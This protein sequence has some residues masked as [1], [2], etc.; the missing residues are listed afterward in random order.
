MESVIRCDN[1][2]VKLDGKI[3]LKD[4]TFDLHLGE[5]VSVTGPSACG[6]TLF[7]RLMAG[8]LQK[9]AGLFDVHTEVKSVFVEQQDNFFAQSGIRHTYY[10]QRYEYFE[11]REVPTVASL[12]KL[13]KEAWQDNSTLASLI[14]TLNIEYLLDRQLLLLSNGERKR[15]QIVAALL[16]QPT[17]LVFDQPFIGLDIES[18]RIVK[19]LLSELKQEGKTV[20]LICSKRDVPSF[21]DRWV[22]MRKGAIETILMP[23]DF[24]HINEAHH[25]HEAHFEAFDLPLPEQSLKF[26]TII[27]MRN[28]NVAI[29]GKTILK[30]I[31]WEVK[32]G[33]RW[34][35]SGHNGSGKSTLLSLVTADNPHG[36]N[37][38]LV[39]FD[40]KRGTGETVWE[41]KKKIGFVSPELHL[42]F[43]RQTH[44]TDH[45]GTLVHS[46][47]ALSVVVSG[48]ND[49]IG[50]SSKPT[51]YQEKIATQ[52]LDSLGLGH[53]KLSQ[54]SE[55]SLGE[56]RMLLLIRA[57]IKNP[58]LLIL[59]EPCQGI[60]YE[61][62]RRFIK[63]LDGLC[64]KLETTL[65]YVSHSLDEIPTC[66]THK[67]VLSEGQVVESIKQKI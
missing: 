31:H 10:S 55:L 3:L 58:P 22:M 29:A 15:V 30:E 46:I 1:L 7:G 64:A 47:D 35:L 19:S 12:L 32:R 67:I 20:V 27:R 8:E 59:D 66:I 34:L 62:S 6:K 54:F 16:Q 25:H 61:Q 53:L 45:R 14:R 17:L 2:E 28:V 36:Y 33:E 11:G 18:K 57:L 40:R 21:S 43:L 50:F 4:I 26:D 63:L 49:E 51:V 52:W 5:L 38:D 37:Q 42:Y 48:F 13:E 56:Q 9:S 39:L 24:Q 65:V 44:L 23:T 41:I 60:D